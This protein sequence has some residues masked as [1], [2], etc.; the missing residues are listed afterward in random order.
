MIREN[1][2]ENSEWHRTSVKQILSHGVIS[3]FRSTGGKTIV[4]ASIGNNIITKA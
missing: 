2:I 3:T 1:K 4:F